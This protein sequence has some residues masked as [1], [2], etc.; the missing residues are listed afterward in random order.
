MVRCLKDARLEM[1]LTQIEVAKKL[2]K[3]QSYVSK[4]EKGERRI[5]AIELAR[6]AKIYRKN[7]NFFLN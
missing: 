5:D 7:I 1:K 4:A 6:F 3:P 2:H